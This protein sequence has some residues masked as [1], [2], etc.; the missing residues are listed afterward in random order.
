MSSTHFSDAH[1]P[2]TN[3]FEIFSGE[4]KMDYPNKGKVRK[5]IEQLTKQTFY[6]N[7]QHVIKT[8]FQSLYLS[9]QYRVFRKFLSFWNL[10]AI[11]LVEIIQFCSLQD[12]KT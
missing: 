8:L 12:R 10:L 7:L 11:V 5:H 1:Q 6:Q 3:I 9:L 4:W 2:I